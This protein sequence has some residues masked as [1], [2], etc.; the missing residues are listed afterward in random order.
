MVGFAG[1]QLEVQLLLRDFA[2]K[3]LRVAGNEVKQFSQT[4]VRSSGAGAVAIKGIGVAASVA[5]G[6]VIGLALTG[7]GA[8]ID[9]MM[10]SKRGAEE[11]N[12][13]LLQ[14][15]NT[16]GFLK[17]DIEIIQRALKESKLL[18]EDSAAALRALGLA[19]QGARDGVEEFAGAFREAGIAIEHFGAARSIDDIT[20]AI[21]AL[22]EEKL[23][24]F[25]QSA[26]SFLPS[27]TEGLDKQFRRIVI[28]SNQIGATRAEQLKKDLEQIDDYYK[29]QVEMST[30]SAEARKKKEKEVADAAK[31]ASEDSA[32]AA[33]KSD[34][35]I[36]KANAELTELLENQ[37]IENISDPIEKIRAQWNK[38]IEAAEKM[39]EAT[40]S[41]FDQSKLNQYISALK[42]ARDTALSV[43]SGTG[44]SGT[45]VTLE[46]HYD[47]LGESTKNAAKEATLATK[48]YEALGETVAA[49]G[50]KLSLDVFD[51]LIAKTKTFKD[52][53]M[54][55]S[56]ELFAMASRAAF[57]AAFKAIVPTPFASGG[58][59]PGG[60][61][62]LQSGGIVADPTLALM[63]EGKN[64]EAVVPLP[65]NKSIPVKF[66]GGLGGQSMNVT[67]AISAMDGPSVKDFFQRNHREVVKLIRSAMH[68]DYGTRSAVMALG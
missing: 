49:W 16:S 36:A 68:S 48:E 51:V 29:A 4:A 61:R 43:A 65:D 67:L 3:G 54:G 35:E 2:S 24:K 8:L 12:A 1:N 47:K 38:L 41:A 60:T 21:N 13:A 25:I 63:G 58:I 20:E 50:E 46:S 5:S 9:K 39:G 17:T 18:D 66:Q 19:Y 10:E 27:G 34:E 6:A 15:S 33:K 56:R 59:I 44:A 26:F 22:P 7:L 28:A 45:G 64:S 30:K 53:L 23:K 32:A 52:V 11:F 14:L 42:Q 55:L 40:D 37:L 31:K 57:M 62:A